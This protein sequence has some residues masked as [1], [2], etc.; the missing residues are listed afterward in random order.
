M[1]GYLTV[2]TYTHTWGLPVIMRKNRVSLH[3]NVCMQACANLSRL[4]K[5]H[6]NGTQN[7]VYKCCCY[8]VSG[9]SNNT[10]GHLG[11]CLNCTLFSIDFAFAPG[12]HVKVNIQTDKARIELFSNTAF[13]LN[14]PEDL[15]ILVTTVLQWE[16]WKDGLMD[17]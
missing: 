17:L 15:L 5:T 7:N 2:A 3:G 8:S 4:V 9:A 12:F 11:R 14:S 1:H 10:F 13:I 6:F 16:F